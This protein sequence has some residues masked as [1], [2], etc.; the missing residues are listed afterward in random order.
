MKDQEIETER[1]DV[2]ITK[3][4]SVPN[5]TEGMI[6]LDQLRINCAYRKQEQNWRNVN[7]KPSLLNEEM[8]EDNTNNRRLTVDT[9]VELQL[10]H[11]R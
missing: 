7:F 2:L 3:R 9:I 10:L 11:R 6:N 5:T 1:R 4:W 8:R